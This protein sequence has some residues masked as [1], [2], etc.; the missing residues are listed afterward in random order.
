MLRENLW[1]LPS[2]SYMKRSWSLIALKVCV[3]SYEKEILHVCLDSDCILF[4]LGIIIIILG[5]VQAQIR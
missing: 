4:L 1:D 5:S 2:H 3:F